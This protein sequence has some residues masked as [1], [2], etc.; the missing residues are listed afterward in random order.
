MPYFLMDYIDSRIVLSLL[1][2]PRESF[3]RIAM[4]LNISAQDMN[5]RIKRIMGSGIVKKIYVTC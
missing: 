3:R 4:D 2:S 1:R 5:Y